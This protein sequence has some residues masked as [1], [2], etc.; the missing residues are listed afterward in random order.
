MKKLRNP[1]TLR[2]VQ[3][4]GGGHCERQREASLLMQLRHPQG[5]RQQLQP[6]G[7]LRQ[8]K[9]P[10]ESEEP[11]VTRGLWLTDGL[12]HMSDTLLGT[13]R[14]VGEDRNSAGRFIHLFETYLLSTNYLPGTV[15][16]SEVTEENGN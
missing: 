12:E 9:E 6:P 7:T 2:A 10:G 14:L 4:R 11:E 13:S 5:G 15:G 8:Q 16:G 1:V 3:L